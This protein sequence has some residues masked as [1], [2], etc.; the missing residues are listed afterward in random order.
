[1]NMTSE[2]A[3][4]KLGRRETQK[5]KGKLNEIKGWI[6]KQKTQLHKKLLCSPFDYGDDREVMR[7]LKRDSALFFLG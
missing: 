4:G 2:I 1:M 3:E 7:G 5:I 6:E